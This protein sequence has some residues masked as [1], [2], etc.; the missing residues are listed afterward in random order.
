MRQVLATK[1][2]SAEAWARDAGMAG[3]T[4]RRFLNGGPEAPTPSLDT[5][6]ALAR[7][8]GYGP[9]LSFADKVPVSRTT[10]DTVRLVRPDL[11]A[12]F[13][14]RQSMLEAKI[15]L[16]QSPLT[17]VDRGLVSQ[18]AFAVEAEH[19]S[20]N[21]IGI[22]V[23]DILVCEPVWSVAPEPNDVVLVDDMGQ[24]MPLTYYP[25]V[26]VPR[27]TDRTYD[28]R[29]LDDVTLLGVVVEMKRH[30]LNR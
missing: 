3:T 19:P 8:A 16:D 11:A 30:V 4:I 23:G 20:L 10:T 27:S 26:A 17:T 29:P 25:P 21:Q 13:A 24:I 18:S 12:A 28:P 5:I 1:R 15:A 7:V 2:M 6:D 22:L 14:S 9:T